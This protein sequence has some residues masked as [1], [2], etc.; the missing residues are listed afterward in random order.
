MREW[1]VPDDVLGVARGKG[2]EDPGDP[3]GGAPLAA[4]WRAAATAVHYAQVS[5]T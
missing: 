4:A 5:A 3:A 2:R 1:R